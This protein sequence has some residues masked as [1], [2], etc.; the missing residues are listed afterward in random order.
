MG[1]ESLYEAGS[2]RRV[3]IRSRF[4][5]EVIEVTFAEWDHCVEG[6]RATGRTT[7]RIPRKTAACYQ[8]V[9]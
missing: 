4:T 1:S 2:R 6:V 5:V 3:T 7:V 8:P 9:A